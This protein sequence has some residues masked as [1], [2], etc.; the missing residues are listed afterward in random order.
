M[1]KKK[2]E[3]SHRQSGLLCFRQE[4][5]LVILQEKRGERSVAHKMAPYVEFALHREVHG[6]KV[7]ITMKT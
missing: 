7:S 1:N 4:H 3:L 2:K 5:G 6:K